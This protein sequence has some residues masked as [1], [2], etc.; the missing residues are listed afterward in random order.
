MKKNLLQPIITLRFLTAGLI[1]FIFSAWTS[2]QENGDE[3]KTL[4][5]YFFILSDN[6]AVDQ[7]PLKKTSADVNIVGVIADVTVHQ[8]YKNEGQHALEAVYTFPASTNAAVYA[9]EMKIGNRR[10]V[11]KIEEKKKARAD[12]E[13]AK[14]EG[15]RASLLEQQRPNVFQMN[16]ANIMPGDEIEVTMK[17][18]EML[19]PE[20]G[21]YKFIYPTVVG[22]RYSGESSSSGASNQFVNTPYQKSGNAP[23]YN[24]DIK[25][26]LSAGMPIQNVTSPSHKINTVYA[27]SSM[28]QVELD[29]SE[30]KGGNRD[31]ILEYQLAGN[32]V[33]S[34]LLLYENGDENFFLMM[35]Q[36]PKKITK[37]EIPPREYVFIVDVSGSMSGFPLTVSKSLIRN[38]VLG[39]YST[40][41]FNIIVFAGSSGWMSEE[42]VNANAANI[43]KAL[44]FIS[45]QNGGGG[46]N[47]LAALQKA[48]SL[49]RT[50]E[51]LSRS[52]VILTDG[53]VDVEKEAFDLIRNNCDKANVFSFG[54][55]SSVN[56]YLIEGMA[57]AGQ[58][59]PQVAINEAQANISAEKF[60]NYINNPVLTQVKTKFS[61]FEAY[62]VEPISVPDVFAER[63][64]II[65]GKYKGAAK[66]S[67][68]IKGSAG[69]KNYSKT[70][71]VSD[72][73][74]DSKNA[75]LRYLWARKRIQSL[76]DY[77]FLR[78]DDERVKEVTDLGLKYNLLTNYTSFVAIEEKVVNDGNL[79][80]VDQPLPMP[81]GVE[82]SAIGFELEVESEESSFA[83]YK[84][85]NIKAL[86]SISGKQ[87]IKKQIETQL[88]KQLNTCLASIPSIDEIEVTV[89][90]AGNVI[91]IEIKGAQVKDEDKQCVMETIYKWNFGQ[92]KIK[93][94]WKF[95]IKF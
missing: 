6:P 47:V 87:T 70:F 51:N 93:K 4:S 73:K 49:P 71:N 64:V 14:S 15:K 25:I 55:G 26:N 72:V 91:S 20:G 65:F 9:M 79:T 76:D 17:Y 89:D 82:N 44:Q 40:D 67:I 52:F 53:Y 23:F 83:L 78:Y 31:F 54:I 88:M 8:V 68:T 66:G 61:G 33:E 50:N 27:Q 74:A 41:K 77:N 94:E 90:A 29:K 35:V 69:T 28:A 59:E 84:E 42:S 30:S 34:G 11:A 10:I 39:L 16:V 56:R 5:P 38:L 86:P 58:G 81:E 36:P 1:L 43:E 3:N 92:Y 18:T 85:I 13:Q 48:M 95:Q 45:S 46:T 7:L 37:E 12:Y 2:A 19:V 62:D 22:P 57:R 75:A 32:K 24:F 80:T 60:R 63:P 21:I